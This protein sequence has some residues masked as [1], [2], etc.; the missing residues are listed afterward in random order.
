MHN[1][2]TDILR[3]SE[4]IELM[5]LRE[6]EDKPKT[7]WLIDGLVPSNSLACIYGPPGSGKSFLAL[8]MAMRISH[9][10]RFQELDTSLGSA[11]YIAGEGVSGVSDRVVAWLDYHDK[12]EGS[13]Y[14]IDRAVDISTKF[15]LIIEA[16]ENNGIDPDLIIIDTLARCFGANDENSTADMQKFILGIDTMRID[17]NCTVLVVHHSSRAERLSLRGNSSFE[18]VLDTIIKVVANPPQPHENSKTTASIVKQKDG[19]SGQRYYY[20]IFPHIDSAVLKSV[21]SA[22]AE[23][24]NKGSQLGLLLA[25]KNMVHSAEQWITVSEWRRAYPLLGPDFSVLV[26]KLVELGHVEYQKKGNSATYRPIN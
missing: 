11:I 10:E 15:P 12:E 4:T 17:L 8:D 23:S 24:E 20:E 16:V 13:F 22:V 3:R 21:P 25:L 2:D 5:T 14:V 26:A 18:G 6:L 19:A 7:R 1:T 9:G